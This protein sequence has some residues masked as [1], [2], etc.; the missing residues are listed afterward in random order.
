MSPTLAGVQ[1]G[2][3]QLGLNRPNGSVNYAYDT[4]NRL[5]SAATTGT[6]CSV[7]AGG[8]KD[9]ATSYVV[10]AWGNLTAKNSTLCQG[11]TMA[12]A[13][14]ATHN[15][16][17]TASYDSAGNLIQQAGAGYTYDAEGRLINGMGTAYTYDGMG[18]RVE[19]AGSKLYWKG[20]G[21]T[22]LM[23]TNSSDQNP[24]MYV[25]FNGARIARVDP[26]ATA[27]YYVTDNVGS[28]EVETDYSGNALNQSLFFPYGVERIVQ[29]ND[30]A[31]NYRFSG[32][33]RDQETGLDDFGARYYDSVVGRFMTPDWDAKPTAVPYASFGDPQTLNL[34][35]YVENGPL[36]RVDADGHDGQQVPNGSTQV[37][38]CAGS[39]TEGCTSGT[40]NVPANLANS[41]GLDAN[42]YQN[43]AQVT[44]ENQ[45]AASASGNNMAQQQS[46]DPTLPTAVDPP[47]APLLD[48][49]LLPQSPGEAINLA[50]M[51]GTDGL[52]EIAEAGA[53]LSR[54]T[55]LASALGKTKDF[56]TLAVTET[57]EGTKVISSSENALRPAV[58][59]LLK[60]GEVAA[61]GA[62]HAEVTGVNAAKQMGLTPTGVAASRG[63]C[64]SCADFLRTAGVAALSALRG[65]GIF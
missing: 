60:E 32:K 51:V 53:A 43:E 44:V 14:P 54:V 17:S 38:L 41:Q 8:T 28:T 42:I 50:I 23:E 9:W 52:G 48:R 29:Q 58:S 1:D 47:P 63:I 2:L 40:T 15:Q 27:K 35:S 26:G 3:D 30:T 16:L 7:M 49:L 31:N 37:P 36:N 10:D 18:E 21:S 34:Y 65:T 64:P 59:S 39:S 24:T 45:Q 19:K 62:G 55:E 20:V 22:A 4:L 12:S 13:A 33:E 25:F 5:N 57:E 6:N 46:G 61:K 56:V 11:E